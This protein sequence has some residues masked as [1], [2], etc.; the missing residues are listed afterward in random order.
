MSS[1]KCSHEFTGTIIKEETIKSL[2]KKTIPNTAVLEVE[3]SYPGYYGLADQQ[4]QP[5]FI[6]L[7]TKKDYRFEEAKRLEKRIKKYC[8]DKFYISSASLEI[9]NKQWP[10]IRIK[11]LSSYDHLKDI[12]E[13]MQDEKVKFVQSKKVIDLKSIIRTDKVFWVEEADKGIYLDLFEKEIGYIR[14]P[15]RLKW[16]A[17]ETVTFM[18]KNN[19]LGKGFD[20]ALGHFNRKKGVE[21][22]VRIYSKENSVELLATIREVY[23]RMIR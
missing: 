17:F 20:A 12:M 9:Q 23:L 16:K 10:A 14:L 5:N 19:W 8:K 11:Q 6:Y 13:F 22:V 7:L 18:V 4:T 2:Q 21:E 15:K 3:D 1:T